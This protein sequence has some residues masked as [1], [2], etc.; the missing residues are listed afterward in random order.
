MAAFDGRTKGNK[1]DAR[2]RLV[3]KEAAQ[4]GAGMELIEPV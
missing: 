2:L 1:P 4:F 3:D